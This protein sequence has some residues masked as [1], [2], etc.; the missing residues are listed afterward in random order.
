MG[1]E[2]RREERK[3]L[4][5]DQFLL[6]FLLA[7]LT[8]RVAVSVV[9]EGRVED[10]LL[11]LGVVQYHVFIECFP[12]ASKDNRATEYVCQTDDASPSSSSPSL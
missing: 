11:S 2:G 5:S 6:L 3:C 1:V 4:S 12:C 9:R 7:S 10:S 8:L